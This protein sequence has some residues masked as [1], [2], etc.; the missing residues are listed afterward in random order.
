MLRCLMKSCTLVRVTL[1]LLRKLLSPFHAA[2]ASDMID[3]DLAMAQD[4]T[5]V[6]SS[7]A[8]LEDNTLTAV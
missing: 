1:G 7:A 6:I 5:V 4:T 3:Q 8:K 2:L